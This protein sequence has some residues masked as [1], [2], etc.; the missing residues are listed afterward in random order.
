MQ[1]V[2]FFDYDGVIADSLSTWYRVY[3][4]I[5]S[6]LGLPEINDKEELR[7]LYDN[8]M[9]ESLRKSGVNVNVAI[10]N[11]QDHLGKVYLKEVP[12]F[13]GMFSVVNNLSKK[14]PLFVITSNAFM[15]VQSHIEKNKLAGIRGVI[16]PEKETSKVEKIKKIMLDFPGAEF[17]Y[18]G[19]TTGD[20]KEGREAKV[21]T[22]AVTWGYHS[23]S[24]LTMVKPDFIVNNPE[25]LFKLLS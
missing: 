23:K 4:K 10:K 25:E 18:I 21:K 19:D 1:R 20:I 16:G 15:V 11:I 3:K 6:K 2:L 14:Y 5:S 7:N 9:Y 22:V 24:K 13:S 17:W 8:N 12:V